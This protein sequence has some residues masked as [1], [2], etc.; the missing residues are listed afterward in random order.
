MRNEK[1]DQKVTFMTYR[2]QIERIDRWR[3]RQGSPIPSRNLAMRMLLDQALEAAEREA[4]ERN[5]G[6]R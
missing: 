6:D 3:G 1:V 2:S 5:G 4:G